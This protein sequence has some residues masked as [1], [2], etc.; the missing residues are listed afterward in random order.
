LDPIV[1]FS[2]SDRFS[3]RPNFRNPFLPPSIY[4]KEAVKSHRTHAINDLRDS[5]PLGDK[6]LRMIV[7]ETREAGAR[8]AARQKYPGIK[9]SKGAPK[10]T[11]VT[12]REVG[13][14]SKRRLL[15]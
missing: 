14:E 3:E 13:R 15:D 9:G 8:L 1:R 5:V 12:G 11:K 4:I 2:D 7:F 6:W 10:D